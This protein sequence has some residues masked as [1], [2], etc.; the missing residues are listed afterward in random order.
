MKKLL[1]IVLLFAG[2]AQAQPSCRYTFSG[3][4][5]CGYDNGASNIYQNAL[6]PIFGAGGGVFLHPMV[7]GGALTNAPNRGLTTYRHDAFGNIRGSD[8][9]LIRRDAFGNTIITHPNGGR[10]TCR[11]DAFGNTRC[12]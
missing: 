9:T 6:R 4:V 2:S 10:T 8:G 3:N 5:L 11:T 12:Q 7:R 1:L